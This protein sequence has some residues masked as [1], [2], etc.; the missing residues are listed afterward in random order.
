[1]NSKFLKNKIPESSS[2]QTNHIGF[3]PGMQIDLTL[4]T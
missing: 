2:I 1:M 3:I 4:E